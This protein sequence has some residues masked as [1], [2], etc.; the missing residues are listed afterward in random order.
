M[1]KR[2]WKYEEKLKTG[3][4]SNVNQMKFRQRNTHNQVVEGKERMNVLPCVYSTNSIKFNSY[5]GEWMKGMDRIHE[6]TSKLIHV[7]EGWY[8]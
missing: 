6:T 4:Q 7:N 3:K 2:S 1:H 8:V 5:A